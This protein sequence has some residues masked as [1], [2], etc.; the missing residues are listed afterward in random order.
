M[1]L[2]KIKNT[3][4]QSVNELFATATVDELTGDIDAY[5]TKLGKIAQIA[6]I[7]GTDTEITE[8]T[9]NLTAATE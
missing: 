5:R 2:D 9:L 3:I 8:I 4:H 1:P 7:L 6:E